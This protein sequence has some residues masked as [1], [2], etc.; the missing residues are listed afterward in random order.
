MWERAFTGV[1]QQQDAVDHS[2]SALHLATE[3]GVAGGVDYV[4]LGVAPADR[5]VLGQDRDALLTFQVR[6]VHDALDHLFV[7]RYRPCLLQHGVDQRRLAVVYVGD[8]RDITYVVPEGLGHG[9]FQARRSA[10]C[11]RETT[12]N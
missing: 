11:L 4:D 1:D 2:Q 9:G 6:R 3:V 12:R 5:R 8:D 7:G 10:G